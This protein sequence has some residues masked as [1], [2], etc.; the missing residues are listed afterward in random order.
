[1]SEIEANQGMAAMAQTVAERRVWRCTG[2]AFASPKLVAII[3]CITNIIQ[4]LM[5]SLKCIAIRKQFFIHSNAIY[6]SKDLCNSFDE[7]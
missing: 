7:I 2:L 1:M 5:Y 4:L 3:R 6:E